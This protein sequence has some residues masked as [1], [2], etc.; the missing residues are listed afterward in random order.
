MIY[1]FTQLY[2]LV[3]T[4]VGT[5]SSLGPDTRLRSRAKENKCTCTDLGFRTKKQ[6]ARVADA[7]GVFLQYFGNIYI[8]NVLL[9]HLVE[10]VATV[11]FFP[12]YVHTEEYSI[13]ST[14]ASNAA[15]DVFLRGLC[16]SCK[17]AFRALFCHASGR[18]AGALPVPMRDPASSR[19]FSLVR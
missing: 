14:P 17:P 15:P 7:A 13:R 19:L 2:G 3:V 16:A 9:P 10:H 4:V 12:A 5:V 8:R 11:D 1:Y 6:C 18:S